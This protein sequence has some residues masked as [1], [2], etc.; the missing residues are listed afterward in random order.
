MVDG[1]F[2]RVGSL[3]KGL[4]P[5]VCIGDPINYTFSESPVNSTHDKPDFGHI[6]CI[7]KKIYLFE[8]EKPAIF[9]LSPTYAVV[10]S[11]LLAATRLLFAPFDCPWSRLFS[12]PNLF[13][14]QWTVVELC[15]LAQST[16]ISRFRRIMTFLHFPNFRE[17]TCCKGMSSCV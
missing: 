6:Y 14:I 16:T 4:A 17:K 11:S 2:C 5:S 9:R 3:P 1:A 10:L 7:S 15:H 13:A 12:A 8:C